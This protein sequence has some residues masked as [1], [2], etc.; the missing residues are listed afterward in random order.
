MI[1]STTDIEGG[2]ARSSYRLHRG[3][4]FLGLRSQMLVQNKFC[5]DRNVIGAK[6]KREKLLAKTQPILNSLPL[7]FYGSRK[8]ASFSSEWLSINN[9]G[10]YIE[11]I[12]PQILNLH[13]VCDGFLSIESLAK[14][15]LPIVWTLH[16]MWPFTGGCHYN[17]SCDRYTES[18]GQCPQLSSSR[19]KDLSHWVWS[20]KMKSWQNLNCTIVTP[21]RWLAECARSSSLFSK[22]RVETIPYGL[23]LE[24]FRPSER[25]YARWWLSLPKDKHLILFTSIQATTD[26]RKGFHFLQDILKTLRLSFSRN[27]IELIIVGASEPDTP[28]DLGFETHYL[29]TLKDDISLA[30]VYGAADVFVAPS[31]QDNLPNTVLESIACGTPCVA[32]NVGGMPD[33]IEHQHNGYL[34]EPYEIQDFVNGIK[35]ILEDKDRHHKLCLKARDKAETEF[36]LLL[37]AQRYK[38]LFEEL[39]GVEG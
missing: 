27:D 8:N 31:V 20:R 30:L 25:R 16:D 36:G 5:D 15:K 9:W 35:W 14:F 32:F 6:L 29:G 18:C 19:S 39:T 34:A 17:Q 10:S 7:I 22:F 11:D 21:S 23:D 4:R 28:L 37:Q 26:R 2:A 24:R 1:F 33:L 12:N 13:W 3:L 38:Q